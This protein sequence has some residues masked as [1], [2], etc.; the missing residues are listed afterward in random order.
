MSSKD[1]K[2]YFNFYRSDKDVNEFHVD[3]RNLSAE[4]KF[5]FVCISY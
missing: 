1:I 2:P 5:L 3:S 4:K